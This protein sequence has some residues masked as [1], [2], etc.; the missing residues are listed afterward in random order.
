MLHSENTLITCCYLHAIPLLGINLHDFVFFFLLF[1][2]LNYL[3]INASMRHQRQL[4]DTEQLESRLVMVSVI[5][6]N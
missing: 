5:E 3:N 6:M 2:N 4:Y 1:S